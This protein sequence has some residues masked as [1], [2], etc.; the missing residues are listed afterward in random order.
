MSVTLKSREDGAKMRIAGVLAAEVLDYVA[1]HVVAGVTT[2]E[3]DR[4]CHEYMVNVQD[5][6]PAPLH[7]RRGIPAVS[8][9][10]LRPSITSSVTASPATSALKPGDIVNIDITV[11]GPGSTATR[12]A[13]SM[14]ARLVELAACARSPR[15]R[16]GAASAPS[17]PALSWAHRRDDPA[18]CREP[19][20]LGSEGNS[21]HGIGR[22]FHENRRCFI[23]DAPARARCSRNDVRHRTDDQRGAPRHPLPC[24]RLDGR[25]YGSQPL[26]RNGSHTVLVTDSGF[27]G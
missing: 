22:Q 5:T 1:P 10:D 4:L 19:Q 21:G 26:R 23:T 27:E 18:P 14:S 25:H 15:G 24:R 2:G 8:G 17:G 7:M 12:A 3:L 20:L 9:V 16:C 6:I 11:I 13:C